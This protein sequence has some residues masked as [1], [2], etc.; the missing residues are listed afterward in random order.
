[1]SAKPRLISVFLDTI[2][3]TP[4]V[5]DAKTT[6]V[7]C[8]FE[9]SCRLFASLDSIRNDHLVVLIKHSNRTVY[10]IPTRYKGSVLQLESLSKLLS[11]FKA[12]ILWSANKNTLSPLIHESSFIDKDL[13]A[14]LIETFFKPF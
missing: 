10:I 12:D 8:F 1:M 7:S 2:E 13:R 14:S 6:A 11:L 3:E 5:V 4:L 9:Y